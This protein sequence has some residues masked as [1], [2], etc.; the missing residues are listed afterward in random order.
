MHLSISSK[1]GACLDRPHAGT[2]W[3]WNDRGRLQRLGKLH[4]RLKHYPG[5]PSL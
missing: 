4:V 1:R 3:E 2:R 5:G